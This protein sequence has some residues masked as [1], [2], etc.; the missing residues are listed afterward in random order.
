MSSHKEPQI[1]LGLL[2]GEEPVRAVRQIQRT[3]V[4]GPVQHDGPGWR[5]LFPAFAQVVGN[6]DSIPPRQALRPSLAISARRS[7]SST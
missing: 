6:Q 4:R 1:V 3:W 7:E 2:D 5:R